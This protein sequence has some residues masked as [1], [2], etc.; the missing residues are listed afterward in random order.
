[1][2]WALNDLTLL[3]LLLGSSVTI[4]HAVDNVMA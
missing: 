2:P 4:A 3:V 1:M